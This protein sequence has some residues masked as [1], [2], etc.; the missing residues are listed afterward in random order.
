MGIAPGIFEET[1]TFLPAALSIITASRF[2]V[3]LF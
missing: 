3:N 2:T 1:F